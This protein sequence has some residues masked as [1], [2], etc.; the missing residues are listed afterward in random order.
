M[1]VRPGVLLVSCALFLGCQKRGEEL[2]V[3]HASSLSRVFGELAEKLK[4]AEPSLTVRLEPS[5]SQ[6]AARKVSEQ[7]LRADLVAVADASLLEKLLGPPRAGPPLIFA[8]NELVLVHLGHSPG[9]EEI[10]SENWP[11]LLLHPGTRLGCVDPELAPLGYHTQLSWQL[12]EL[13]LARPGL[14]A[15]LLAACNPKR[16]L[17]DEAELLAL[18][19]ARAIDYAFVYRSSAEDHRLKVTRLDERYNLGSTAHAG[20]YA[21][22]S[23]HLRVGSGQKVK[24][25]GGPIT[26]GLAVPSDAPN[27]RA[28]KAFIELLRSPEGRRIFSRHGFRAAL[29]DGGAP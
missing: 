18:L 8:T 15:Q 20:A 14:S 6:V 1:L 29:A 19:E 13:E 22:A 10:T 3:F 17:P 4:Q 25:Q 23:L 12:A 9:T 11:E 24:L 5:G 28:A 2:V 21:R 7:G 26:Y 16:P 27:P